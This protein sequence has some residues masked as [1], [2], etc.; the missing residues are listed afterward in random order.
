MLCKQTHLRI[1]TL[2]F[3]VKGCR[4]CKMFYLLLA[5]SSTCQASCL[6]REISTKTFFT[7]YHSTVSTRGRPQRPAQLF[8]LKGT[9]SLRVC[10]ALIGPRDK[11]SASILPP[12][13]N[14]PPSL[15]DAFSFQGVGSFFSS[16]LRWRIYWAAAQ[17]LPRREGEGGEIQADRQSSLTPTTF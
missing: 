7:I 11:N 15:S 13:L 4:L 8:P 2:S 6:S 9:F 12:Y 17:P 1:A 5:W 14:L 10:A 3:T 16:P